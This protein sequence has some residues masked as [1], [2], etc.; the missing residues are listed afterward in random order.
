MLHVSNIGLRATS[1]SAT[2]RL[3]PGLYRFF[4][5]SPAGSLSPVACPPA[6]ALTACFPSPV[7]SSAWPDSHQSS[8]FPFP[9][10]KGLFADVVI[11]AN[12]LDRLIPVCL[13]QYP[14]LLFDRV[15]FAF[16]CLWS[17]YTNW[18]TVRVSLERLM[19]K[20]SW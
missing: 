14:Y 16:H 12:L 20:L 2:C 11:T 8:K 3:C 6:S 19:L 7:S 5:G 4:R 15:S 13:P 9:T 17:G 10:V 18:S 1:L